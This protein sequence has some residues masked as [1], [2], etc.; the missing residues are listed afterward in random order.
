MFIE[1]GEV[2][3]KLKI[4]IYI[5]KEQ[6]SRKA[7]LLSVCYHN[8]VTST[9]LNVMEMFLLLILMNLSGTIVGTSDC[10]TNLKFEKLYHSLKMESI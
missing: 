5:Y 7:L 9:Y 8:Y 6:K 10:L 4:N 2:I 1:T 3:E